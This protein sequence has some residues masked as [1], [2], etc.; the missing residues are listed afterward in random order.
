M[1]SPVEMAVPAANEAPENRLVAR[2][3][4]VMIF[5]MFFSSEL[6]SSHNGQDVFRIGGGY[7]IVRLG[8]ILVELRNSDGSQNA[9]DRNHNHQLNQ[10]KA[11][12][13]LLDKF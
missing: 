13:L 12:L 7:G 4:V 10:G 2:A 9:N 3:R 6:R 5:L 1:R 8:T 11:F